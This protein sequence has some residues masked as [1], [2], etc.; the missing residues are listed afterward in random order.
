[1]KRCFFVETASLKKVTEWGKIKTINKKRK[2]LKK[3]L[4]I[5]RRYNK[6]IQHLEK[7]ISKYKKVDKA[8][9]DG[10]VEHGN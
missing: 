5:N 1:M 2:E 7:I 9:P 10:M 8:I 4:R 6:N 3:E